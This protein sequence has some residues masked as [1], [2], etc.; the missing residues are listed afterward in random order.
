MIF[1]RNKLNAKKIFEPEQQNCCPPHNNDLFQDYLNNTYPNRL[2]C[3]KQVTIF[4]PARLPD[5][6]PMIFIE[7]VGIFIYSHDEFTNLKNYLTINDVF[8]NISH[9]MLA[10]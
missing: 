6:S 5:P 4:W 1:Y 7:L 9:N 2:I 3:R 10:N 8:L